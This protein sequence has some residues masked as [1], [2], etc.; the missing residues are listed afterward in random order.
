M[1]VDDLGVRSGM[2][3]GRTMMLE[4]AAMENWPRNSEWGE[5]STQLTVISTV[6]VL[7]HITQGRTSVSD[8]LEATSGFPLKY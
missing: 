6:M 3:I 7:E 5:P 1:D 4:E 8:V 2:S